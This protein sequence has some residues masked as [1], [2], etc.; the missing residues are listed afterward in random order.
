[1]KEVVGLVDKKCAAAST[2]YNSRSDM[3]RSSAVLIAFIYVGV[4]DVEDN[5]DLQGAYKE[6]SSM[7]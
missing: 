5:M 1:M 6:I 4:I 3:K 2:Q 7:I